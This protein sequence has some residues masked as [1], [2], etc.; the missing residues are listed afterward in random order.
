[1]TEPIANA[2][3][4]A[5]PLRH[6]R[7]AYRVRKALEH[8]RDSVDVI[9]VNREEQAEE[10]GQP[11][12]EAGDF[13]LSVMDSRVIVSLVG[14]GDVAQLSDPESARRAVRELSRAPHIDAIALVVDDADMSTA[15]FDP[16]DRQ[17]TI[18][19]P[20]GERH[21]VFPSI[22]PM[23]LVEAVEEFLYVFSVDWSPVGSLPAFEI[24]DMTDLAHQVSVEALRT[25]QAQDYRIEEKV[26]A[27][28]SLSA[29]DAEWVAQLV[30]RVYETGDWADLHEQVAR[31]GSN[32]DS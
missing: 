26:S 20:S 6:L 14:S 11:G 18:H 24:V 4:S 29:S 19:V 31:R 15:F 2:S 23:P 7:L 25:L 3:A 10:A 17:D 1:M 16:F 32:E 5:G 12:A 9:D 21:P 30:V 27:R 13:L 8:F 28:D 22:G